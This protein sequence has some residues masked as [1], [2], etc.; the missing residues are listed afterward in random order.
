MTPYNTLQRA[1]REGGSQMQ[2]TGDAA[3]APRLVAW[4]ATRACDLACVHCRAVAQSVPDSRQLSTEEAFRLVD[5]IAA[6]Q[7]PGS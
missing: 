5:D 7:Q 2:M 1:H 6:F 3:R 4:E